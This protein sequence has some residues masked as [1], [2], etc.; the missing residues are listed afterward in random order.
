MELERAY[1]VCF[2]RQ[3]LRW[4][5]RAGDYL[6]VWQHGRLLGEVPAETVL[7]AL[8]W[9][10]TVA[11]L[12]A[13]LPGSPAAHAPALAALRAEPPGLLGPRLPAVHGRRLRGWPP[14]A[15]RE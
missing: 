2:P 1:V 3:G 13:A 12:V 8:G 7:D 14:E 4:P 6:E 15:P 11:R 10:W 9:L 5:L